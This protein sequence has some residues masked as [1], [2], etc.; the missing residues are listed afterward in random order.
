MFLCLTCYTIHNYS[1]LPVLSGV[2][3]DAVDCADAQARTSAFG[4]CQYRALNWPGPV[5]VQVSKRIPLKALRYRGL[6]GISLK[7]DQSSQRAR[8]SRPHRT[9]KLQK[10]NDFV[11][12][13]RD[14]LP[15]FRCDKLK[16]HSLVFHRSDPRSRQRAQFHKCS[17]FSCLFPPRNSYRF[18]CEFYFKY[19]MT[20]CKL[21]FD[22]IHFDTG[23]GHPSRRWKRCRID[24]VLLYISFYSLRNLRVLGEKLFH[25]LH[26]GFMILLQFVL[27]FSCS[28]VCA[29]KCPTHLGGGGGVMV[30]YCIMIVKM[31]NKRKKES[32]DM[33]RG[34][35][36]RPGV[37]E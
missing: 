3:N 19:I 25:V 8:N 16:V 14:G 21:P 7:M 34:T 9:L 6:N 35:S 31:G 37:Q 32:I 18:W 28:I 27:A 12:H 30:N 20:G 26:L 36:L 5:Q 10:N 13:A 29:V 11:S 33:C 23:I 22:L 1:P 15:Q 4:S 24:G 17:R 2:R